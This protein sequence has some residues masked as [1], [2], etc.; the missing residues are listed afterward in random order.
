MAETRPGV[1]RLGKQ[2]LQR[3]KAVA[4]QAISGHIKSCAQCARAGSDPHGRCA[5]WWQS[6][7][8]IHRM[9]RQLRQYDA[10]STA[11]MDPLFTDDDL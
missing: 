7:R 4:Q 5:E 11:G 3:Q 1:E 10:H 9:T 6:S 2:E 8:I